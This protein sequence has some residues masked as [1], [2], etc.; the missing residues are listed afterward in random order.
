MEQDRKYPIRPVDRQPAELS[1]PP[2]EDTNDAAAVSWKNNE[3][4][5]RRNRPNPAANPVHRMHLGR[6]L[7]PPLRTSGGASQN[8]P[9]DPRIITPPVSTGK[10]HGSSR[11]SDGTDID[12]IQETRQA[13][14]SRPAVELHNS[15]SD[16]LVDSAISSNL[17]AISVTPP[18]DS[19]NHAETSANLSG[20]AAA[21]SVVMPVQSL[22]VV[23]KLKMFMVNGSSYQKIE[24]IGK[25]GSSKVYKI[26]SPTGKIMALKR[27]K[28]KGL[29]QET[30]E[31]LKNEVSLLEK[32]DDERIIK[33][34]DW[35]FV[36][37]DSLLMLL[38]YGEIDLSNLM[39]KENTPNFIRMYWE[40]VL[41][42]RARS[43]D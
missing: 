3:V 20:R 18:S 27:V 35:Q 14:P 11:A 33:L 2:K 16:R 7:G 23:D 41:F 17:S 37:G 9:T 28:L 42:L 26:I 12:P 8:E 19:R 13:L 36:P 15:P 5:V 29:D 43:I 10:T 1:K 6:K 21:G 30:I 40:Q 34:F 24:L 39:R 22:G 4:P 32:L 31:G 38:E 25:G